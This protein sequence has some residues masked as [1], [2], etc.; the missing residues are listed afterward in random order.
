M[1][2]VL[3]FFTAFMVV[4]SYNMSDKYKE[5]ESTT[6]QSI[7]LAISDEISLAQKSSSGY[8]RSFTIADNIQGKSYE[9]NL[10]D[11][12]IY[13]QVSDGVSIL[14][15]L[16]NLTNMKESFNSTALKKY[17]EKNT[18]KKNDSGVYL[19]V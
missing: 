13:I 7:A 1:G 4:I 10:S 3:V 15:P 9:T 5:R 17:P 2:A 19:N 12:L 14:L 11:S 6:A 18:I 16:G 8:S